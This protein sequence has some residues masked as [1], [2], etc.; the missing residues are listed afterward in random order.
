MKQKKIKVDDPDGVINRFM[1]GLEAKHLDKMIEKMYL[2]GSRARG[3]EK[4]DSDYD[5]LV[6]AASADKRFRSDLYD[7]AVD[8]LLEMGRD[9][10][11]KIFRTDEFNRLR[12]MGTPFMKNVLSEGVRIG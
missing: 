5:L 10:S 2:F 3:Q 12:A 1:R 9:V 11:L 4:P 6:V 8:I 7:I